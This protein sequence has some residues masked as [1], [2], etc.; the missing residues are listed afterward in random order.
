MKKLDDRPYQADAV[1]RILA[2]YKTHRRVL[3]VMHTAGGKTVVAVRV[4]LAMLAKGPALFIVHRKTLVDQAVKSLTDGGLKL[5]QIG[6]IMAGHPAPKP[7][8]LVYVAMV[9]SL[10][11]RT[12]PKVSLIVIDETH[13][14]AAESYEKLLNLYPDTFVLGLTATPERLDGRPMRDVGF[15]EMI[16]GPEPAWLIDKGYLAKPPVFAPHPEVLAALQ[17]DLRKMRKGK[18]DYE[19]GALAAVVGSR[20]LVGDVLDHWKKYAE[21]QTTALFAVNV[22]QAERYA[23]AFEK[24][25]YRAECIHG[26][27]KDPERKAILARLKSGKTKVVTTCDVLLEGWDMPEVTALICVRPTRSKTVWIQMTGR[28][29]RPF[30]ETTPVVLDHAGNA[31]RLGLPHMKRKWSLDAPPKKEG[32]A[33]GDGEPVCKACPECQNVCPV[34][35]TTCDGCGFVWSVTHEVEGELV[36]VTG[37]KMCVGGWFGPCPKGNVAGFRSKQSR[38]IDCARR[39]SAK[40]NGAKMT[41]EQRRAAQRAATASMTSEQFRLR[42]A[43]GANK[44]ATTMTP[45]RRSAAGRKIS[46]AFTPERRVAAGR[47][48]KERMTPERRQDMHRSRKASGAHTKAWATR[49]ARGATGGSSPPAAGSAK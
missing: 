46:A 28:V 41:V 13:R 16:E 43:G 31:L 47:T 29:V 37:P 3:F 5:G 40:A 18:G 42:T 36:E 44:R 12:K 24:A 30:G 4:I 35:A 8:V 1:V 2:A 11:R 20:I 19:Q 10:C 38:C 27:T 33:R 6:I 14:A 21:G 25:G 22:E 17:A 48:L 15:T 49:R 23:A 26:E 9:Q 7:G 34:A 45:E 32:K 39:V